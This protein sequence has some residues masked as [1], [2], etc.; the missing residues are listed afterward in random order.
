MKLFKSAVI[1]ACGLAA[2]AAIASAQ[3]GGMGMRPPMPMGIFTPTV[4]AGAVYDETSQDGT[5]N[6]IEYDL[7]GKESVGGHDGFW[8]EFVT[9]QR[10]GQMV[11]KMLIVPGSD[12]PATHMIMQMGKNPPMEMSQMMQ[13]GS[14]AK[15]NYDVRNGSQD[16]GKESVTTPAGTFACEH[17]QHRR[18]HLGQQPGP[19]LRH[20]QV[21]EQRH[22]ARGHESRIRRQ[23]QNR[24]HTGP[25]QS[26]ADDARNAESVV[27]QRA[28]ILSGAARRCCF[29]SRRSRDLGPRSRRISPRRNKGEIFSGVHHSRSGGVTLAIHES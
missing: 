23:R 17:F 1:C 13:Q 3:R 11:M 28:V 9:N 18:R 21:R 6:T 10:M 26:A 20:G 16:L 2:W 25:I 14:G 8:L 5:K 29:S 27:D 4:G 7:I 12:Q 19:A 22:H 15:P 24:R